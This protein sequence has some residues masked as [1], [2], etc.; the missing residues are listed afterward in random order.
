[1]GPTHME[2]PV[3]WNPA[4]LLRQESNGNETEPRAFGLVV[5]NQPLGHFAALRRIW[6]NG[7]S[8]TQMVLLGLV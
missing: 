6:R 1:M 4:E 7:I 8:I 3:Q 5:L 2:P